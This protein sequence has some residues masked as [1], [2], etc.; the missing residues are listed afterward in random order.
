MPIA[1]ATSDVNALPV[2]RSWVGLLS[3]LAVFL[4]FAAHG[5]W[6]VPDVN[7]AHYLT[8]ARHYWD[9]GW[10]ARDF[11]LESADSH[12]VFCV[13]FGWLGTLVSFDAFAWIGRLLTWAL[14]AAMFYRL[15]AALRLGRWLAPLA[16]ALFVALNSRFGV[17]GE[18]VIGGFE[19]KGIAYAAVLCALER[20]LQGRWN[21]AL[22][23]VGIATA[24]HVLVGGW[25]AIALGFA[26]LMLG[27]DRPSLKEFWPGLVVAACLAV[28]ALGFALALNW[29]VDAETVDR[30]NRIY[31]FGRLPHHLLPSNF[32]Q[33]ALL[34]MAALWIA[35]W[36]LCRRL[37]GDVLVS[38]LRGFVNGAIVIAVAG[39]AVFVVTRGNG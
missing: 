24:F 8:K 4:V 38:R 14:L 35:W 34:R 9:P 3:V 33:P 25:S 18:W 19:A 21:Q 37:R 10:A 2:T 15:C 1:A 27:R 29:G 5:G 16:A 7:E 32:G 22:V 23:A 20:F 17:A 26:W 30:A 28:P 6:Q 39:F 12:K 13:A 36:L 11:F 31:V